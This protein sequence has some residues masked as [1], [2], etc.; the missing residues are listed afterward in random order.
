MRTQALALGMAFVM[1][2][3]L[4]P[5]ALAQDAACALRPSDFGRV[6]WG[7][8]KTACAPAA[9]ATAFCRSCICGIGRGL[10]SGLYA[11]GVQLDASQSTL[12]RL[13][14]TCTSTVGGQLIQNGGFSA[15]TLQSLAACNVASVAGECAAA[16]AAEQG[17]RSAVAPLGAG[18]ATVVASSAG[19]ALLAAAPALLLAVA[20]AVLA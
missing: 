9:D 16:L 7:V 6:D 13:L 3:A 1:A 17:T 19:R 10:V 15:N 14:N 2:G 20:A 11:A 12:D 5:V 8:V 4:M 18:N